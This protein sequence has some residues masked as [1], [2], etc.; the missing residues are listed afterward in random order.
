MTNVG[1]FKVYIENYLIENPKINEKMMIMVRQ[2]PSSEFGLPIEI[3]TFSKDKSWKGYE[4][5]IADIFDHIFAVA[6]SFD[7]EIFENP[8]GSDFKNLARD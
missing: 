8:T 4:Y 7:L 6:E 3:Y 5:I 1:V 2:L